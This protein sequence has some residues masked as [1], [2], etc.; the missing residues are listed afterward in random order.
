MKAKQIRYPGRKWLKH[1]ALWAYPNLRDHLPDTKLY[2]TQAFIDMIEQYK[3]VFV[4]PDLGMQG[5]GVMKV[6][7]VK[8]NGGGY[9]IRTADRDY[10]YRNINNAA[11]RLSLLIGQQQYL[12]QQGIDLIQLSGKPVDFRA[13][14]HIRPGGGQWRFFG[15]MGKVAAPNRI[16]T[17]YSSGGRAI[18]L[19]QALGISIEESDE[20]E[21]RIKQL[22][23]Q[24]AKA[25]KKSFPRITE[26]GLDLAIDHNKQIWLLEANTKPH[27]RLFRHHPNPNL[28]AKIASSARLIRSNGA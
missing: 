14:L 17:N 20:W 11:K 23:G 21:Q 19:H 3:V 16:V 28:F 6:T 26:L 7:A 22:S 8:D 9:V 25:M 12:V 10:A 27:Y 24:I 15:V 13:L 4:K 1:E 5:K 18:R 2:S